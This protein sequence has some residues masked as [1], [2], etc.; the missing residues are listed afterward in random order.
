MYLFGTIKNLRGMPTETNRNGTIAKGRILVKKL[1]YKT[2]K[3]IYN[4]YI[5]SLLTPC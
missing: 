4:H 1:Y 3:D 5:I 2:F